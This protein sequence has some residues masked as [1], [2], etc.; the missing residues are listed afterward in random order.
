MKRHVCKI[1]RVEMN[2]VNNSML[3]FVLKKFFEQYSEISTWYHSLLNTLLV[4][5][6]KTF[7]V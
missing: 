5:S 1:S 4:P 7:C 6:L 2:K 3:L